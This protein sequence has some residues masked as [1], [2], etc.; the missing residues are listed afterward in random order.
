MKQV[1]RSYDGCPEVEVFDGEIKATVQADGTTVGITLI[2]E[3]L[4]DVDT[5]LPSWVDRCAARITQGIADLEA[6]KAHVADD[7]SALNDLS[8]LG[9]KNVFWL[10]DGEA[11]LT[12][13]EFMNRLRLYDV[14]HTDE[15]MDLFFDDGGMFL[16]HSIMVTKPDRVEL[17]G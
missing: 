2:P 1:R 14:N 5:G 15:S 6:I 9:L 7:P 16:G 12:K 8:F 4:T 10:D 13:A 11:P 3:F 17:V